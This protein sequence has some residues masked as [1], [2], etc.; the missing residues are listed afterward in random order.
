M[1]TG[2][3]I[4]AF[5]ALALLCRYPDAVSHGIGLSG[6]YDLGRFIG[7]DGGEDLYMATPLH[8]LPGLDGAHLD[9]LRQRFA[10]LASG[11]GRWE[12]I[13]ESWALS[14]MLGTKGVPNRVDPWGTEYDHDWTTWRRM[15]P[16]YLSELT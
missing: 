13:G 10:I 15:L 14:H 5:N 12:N 1:A 9:M 11:E 4:G 6:T 8:F 2:A 3:S 16:R 7:G